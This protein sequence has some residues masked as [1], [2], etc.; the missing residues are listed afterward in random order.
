MTTISLQRSH[1]HGNKT[2]QK[3]FDATV[4]NLV[5]LHNE[6]LTSV[7]EMNLYFTD[8]VE[9]VHQDWTNFMKRTPIIGCVK[10]GCEN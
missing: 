6:I 2:K 10:N 1:Y 3:V 5:I 8:F 7:Q 9:D 4:Y